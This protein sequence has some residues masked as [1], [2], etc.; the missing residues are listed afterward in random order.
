M[1]AEHVFEERQ[2]FFNAAE[3]HHITLNISTKIG[4]L[5]FYSFKFGYIQTPGHTYMII[6]FI[7]YYISIFLQKK[8]G[9]RN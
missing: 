8:K 3:I 5:H 6:I 9:T 2:S 1:I 4:L 7:V